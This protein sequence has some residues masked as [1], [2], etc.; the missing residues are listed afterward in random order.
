MRRDGFHRHFYYLAVE[1][2]TIV[3]TCGFFG[4]FV[5]I[6]AATKKKIIS[7]HITG[8]TRCK[9]NT[10]LIILYFV[11]ELWHRHVEKFINDINCNTL[12]WWHYQ[13]HPLV[14]PPVAI[15]W[16]HYQWHIR[17]WH[18]QWLS[19]SGTTSGIHWR[20]HQWLPVGGTISGCP[21][22]APEQP[23]K[24]CLVHWTNIGSHKIH[25]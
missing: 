18:Q 8:P 10:I 23:I 5:I 17:W 15:R 11:I 25:M 14:A 22:V 2:V 19:V 20:H 13:W 9:N 1:C 21:L 6:K 4:D 16:W 12:L 24:W 7:M 3:F